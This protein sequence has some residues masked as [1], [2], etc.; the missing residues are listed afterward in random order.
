MRREVLAGLALG[1]ILGDAE[2]FSPQV[3][4]CR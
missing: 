4:R 1:A 3:T 2:A